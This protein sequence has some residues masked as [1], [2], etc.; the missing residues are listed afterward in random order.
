MTQKQKRKIEEVKQ[1]KM[2]EF[3][4]VNLS[5]C[6]IHVKKLNNPIKKKTKVVRLLK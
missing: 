4:H 1:N 2:V 5:T 6:V 3:L